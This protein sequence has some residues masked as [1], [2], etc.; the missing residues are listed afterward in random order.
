MSKKITAAL[1]L[2]LAA[3]A[4]L[5]DESD[6]GGF[7]TVRLTENIHVVMTGVGGNIGVLSGED[8]VFMIDDDLPPLAPKIDAA[9]RQIRDEPVRMVF[10]THW[11]PDHVGGNEYFAGQGALIVAHDNVHKRM[12]TEQFSMFT[13]SDVTPSPDAALP[14]VTFSETITFH[15]NGN[16]V[17]AQHIPLG[18]TDGDAVLYFEEANTIHM[19]DL[20]FNGMYPVIDVSAGGSA[21]GMIN[22]IDTVRPMLNDATVIIPGHGPI[23]NVADLEK[24][25]NMLAT[26][27]NRVRILIAEGKSLD[28]VIALKPSVTFDEEWAWK[29]IPPE[30]FVKMVFQGLQNNPDAVLQG[31][32]AG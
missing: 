25:R 7:Q 4:P 2:T 28:E 20:F 8:G 24:F 12:S 16:T 13:E 15:L 19:G 3:G 21:Q 27:T 17:R 6:K 23:T 29:L 32:A 5:A 18:H 22:A 9:I 30:F 31:D 11:H 10:N 14:V 1:A 26:V